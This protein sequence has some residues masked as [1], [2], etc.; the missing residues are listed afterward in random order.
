MPELEVWLCPVH[1]SLDA[2]GQLEGLDN[3]VACLRAQRNELQRALLDLY[4]NMG[5][6]D[7]WD[8]QG[9]A[10]RTCPVC[11]RQRDARQRVRLHVHDARVDLPPK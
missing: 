3:C 8:A 9:N 1:A 10:G 2:S 11:I 7:H 6:H 4:D 5:G